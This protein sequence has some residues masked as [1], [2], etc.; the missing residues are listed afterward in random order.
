VLVLQVTAT[1]AQ[2]GD[3]DQPEVITEQTVSERSDLLLR[4][5]EVVELVAVAVDRRHQCRHPLK[6]LRAL[7]FLPCPTMILPLLGT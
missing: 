2:P 3:E 5:L 4:L 6:L 1:E 7:N